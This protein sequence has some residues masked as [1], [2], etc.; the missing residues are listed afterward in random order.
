MRSHI[1]NYNQFCL[2]M[3]YFVLDMLVA[4]V[5]ES[6]DNCMNTCTEKVDFKN[7]ML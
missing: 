6:T 7:K 3:N 1:K 5:V 2:N 4:A